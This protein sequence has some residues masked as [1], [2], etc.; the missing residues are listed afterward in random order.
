MILGTFSRELQR[1]NYVP[2]Q[3]SY[4]FSWQSL[5]TSSFS[6]GGM[7]VL[8]FI[9][10]TLFFVSSIVFRKQVK[11]TSLIRMLAFLLVW[12]FFL[13]RQVMIS[14]PQRIVLYPVWSAS[15]V[16]GRAL[17]EC[18]VDLLSLNFSNHHTTGY[19]NVLKSLVCLMK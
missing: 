8:C 3:N 14:K 19:A 15:I 7:S 17:Y 1:R 11:F 10:N 2:L 4:W 18:Q 16:A 6:F 5:R 12:E 13:S 9:L